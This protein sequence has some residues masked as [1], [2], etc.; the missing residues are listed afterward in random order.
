MHLARAAAAAPHRPM[1][2]MSD[3]SDGQLGAAASTSGPEQQQHQQSYE[4]DNTS[5][6]SGGSKALQMSYDREYPFNYYTT[7]FVKLDANNWQEHE[8]PIRDA[9]VLDGAQFALLRKQQRL[10]QNSSSYEDTIDYVSDIMIP[11]DSINVRVHV[12]C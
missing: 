8:P 9:R 4:S 5:S 6:S 3:E 7:E 10:S 1:S 11:P 12:A 2:P